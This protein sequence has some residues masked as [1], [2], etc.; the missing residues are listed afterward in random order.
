MLLQHHERINGSGYPRG[1]TGDKMLLESKI[2]AVADV[3]EAM[4]SHR[5]YRAAHSLDK[6]LAEISTNRGVLF[7]TRIVD[8]CLGLFSR[9]FQFK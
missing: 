7:D 2:L 8:T 4:V 3:V 1:L 9:G 6:A 5:P